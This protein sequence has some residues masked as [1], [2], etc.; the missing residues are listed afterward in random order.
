MGGPGDRIS[1]T[2]E[3]MRAQGA[4][5]AD[6]EAYLVQHEGLTPDGPPRP[7][8][9]DIHEQFRSGRLQKHVARENLNDAEALAAEQQ[10]QPGYLG[11]LATHAANVSQ[12][13]PGMEA[14]Q[15][16]AR[17]LVRGQPYRAALR[18]IQGATQRIPTPLRIAE[19]VA[20]AVPLAALLPGSPALGGAVIGGADQALNASP[21]MSLKERGIRTGIGA[22]GGAVLGKFVDA[23]VTG[24]RAVLPR[25]LGGAGNPASVLLEK[26]AERAKSASDMYGAAMAEGRAHEATP[27]IQEFLADPDI[28]AITEGLQQLD[29]FANVPAES[30]EMLH[31]IYKTLSDQAGKAKR[32]LEA[33]TPTQANQGRFR[34]SDIRGKQQN[35][36]KAMGAG[37]TAVTPET[38][39]LVSETVPALETAQSPRPDIR[40]ALDA[41]HSRPGIA[42]ARREGTVAQQMARE[43]LERHSAENVVSPALQGAPVARTLTKEVVTPEQVRYAPAMMPSY[44]QAVKDFAKRSREIDAIQ[45]GYDVHRASLSDNTPTAKNLTRKTPEAFAE[46][47]AGASPE[48]VAAARQGILGHTRMS[49]RASANPFTGFGALPNAAKATKAASLLR[50][51]QTPN[52]TLLE[53]IQNLGLLGAGSSTQP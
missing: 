40:T 34:L 8:G 24:L 37:G 19:R 9:G 4:T 11:R 16:G 7:A 21:D 32:G 30:P 42:A 44:E 2:I 35:L 18:D 12:G 38:R 46:W 3:A 14:A 53:M 31:A 20:G 49:M 41:F 33:L 51:A 52:Q 26:Q 45:R 25:K 13:I 48:E 36:L 10:D 5:E 29:E 27:A 17:S 43:S 23:G 6:I 28:K 39:T 1:R 22:V 47:A 50:D 15:A